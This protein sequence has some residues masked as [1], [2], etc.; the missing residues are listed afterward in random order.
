MEERRIGVRRIL[1]IL[2]TLSISMDRFACA[3]GND[4]E[5][6]FT[7]S[8]KTEMHSDSDSAD[9]QIVPDVTVDD[10]LTLV[11]DVLYYGKGSIRTYCMNE[12]SRCYSAI[13][14]GG[15]CE[16]KIYFSGQGNGRICPAG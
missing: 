9:T 11:P 7:A 4:H 14:E 10:V 1:I 5:D 3:V 12:H 2:L 8:D 16:K 13:L 6:F 15:L